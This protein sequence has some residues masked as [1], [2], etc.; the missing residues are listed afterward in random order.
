MQRCKGRVLNPPMFFLH[1]GSKKSTRKF[2]IDEVIFQTEF[3][4]DIK[5]RISKG[6]FRT[7]PYGG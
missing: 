6:G 5:V 3:S 1:A 7:R 4:G 2:V